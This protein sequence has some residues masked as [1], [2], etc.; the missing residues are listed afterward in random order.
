VIEAVGHHHAAPGGGGGPGIAELRRG[1][2]SVGKAWVAAR[3]RARRAG[4]ETDAAN[5]MV[6]R[7][8]HNDS[9]R[10]KEREAARAGEERTGSIGKA[11]RAIA[12][13]CAHSAA[14]GYATHAVAAAVGDKDFA[15]CAHS[16][17]ARER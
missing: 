1:A 14:W 15:A 5:A 10:A 11:R 17:R 9:A 4:G 13:E 7:V 16:Q 12:R 6:V 3:Y 2:D 8:A